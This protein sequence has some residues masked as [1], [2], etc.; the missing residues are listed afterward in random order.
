MKWS[1]FYN[2]R[3]TESYRKYFWMK[4]RPFIDFI[5]DIAS[6]IEMPA[7]HEQACGMGNVTRL[8]SEMNMVSPEYLSASEI[9]PEMLLMAA[10]TLFSSGKEGIH[11]FRED[12]FRPFESGYDIIHSHGFLE[13]FDDE[14]INTL[15]ETQLECAHHVVHY[16]PSALYKE[17]SFGDERLMSPNDWIQIA[18][19]D[20]IIEFNNGFDLILYW[21]KND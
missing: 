3:N 2:G 1:E 10:N 18:N 12:A 9:D 16:V 17:P 15:I 19:P 13:H 14:K 21:T 6:S 7:V 11:L 20:D 8:L 4:Y 5:G